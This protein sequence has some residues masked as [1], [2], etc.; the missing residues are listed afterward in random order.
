LDTGVVACGGKVY[1]A[2]WEYEKKAKDGYPG[3]I[4]IA[5]GPLNYLIGPIAANRVS[6][7][8]IN[9]LPAVHIRP[10][11]ASGYGTSMQVI[12]PGEVVTYITS[13]GIP[14]AEVISVAELVAEAIREQS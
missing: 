9:G 14:Q 6:E 13:S 7:K 8:V 5:R 11:S 2:R 1:G 3:S 4:I 12:F 10:L